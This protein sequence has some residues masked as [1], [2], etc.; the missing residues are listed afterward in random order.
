MRDYQTRQAVNDASRNKANHHA[1]PWSCEE[2]ELLRE[3]WD[4]TETTL[5]EIAETL[6]RTIE[7]CRQ[8]YYYPES[9][10][11][12]RCASAPALWT[13]GF[14]TGCGRYTDVKNAVCEDCS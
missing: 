7:A 11:R 3:I 13:M 1:L 10:G 9:G 12:P 14:C 5:Q 4:G 6:G 8:K 2:V